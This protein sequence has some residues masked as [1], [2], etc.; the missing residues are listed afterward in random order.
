MLTELKKVSQI[1]GEPKR[2]WFCD[3]YFDLIVWYSKDDD[4]IGFQLCYDKDQ[5]ERALTWKNSSDYT[6]YRVDDGESRLCPKGIPI[7]VSD[8]MF[9]HDELV[10]RFL[11]E[12]SAIEKG[13]SKFVYNKLINFS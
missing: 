12:S 8:G 11:K 13:L 9:D 2:R 1:P 3:D 4:I 10:D 6:H 5:N 7:L